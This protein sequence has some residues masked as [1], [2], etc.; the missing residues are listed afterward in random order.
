[1]TMSDWPNV[2]FQ[3]PKSVAA[4]EKFAEQRQS[5]MLEIN[6]A[7]Y[8]RRAAYTNLIVLAGYAG[9]FSLWA[10]VREDITTQGNAAIAICLSVSLMLFVGFEIFKMSRMAL[11]SV[12]VGKAFRSDMTALEVMGAVKE[13]RLSQQRESLSRLTKIWLVMLVLTL[14]SASGAVALL[15]YNMFAQLLGWTPWP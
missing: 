2:D 14:L 10:F 4:F 3:N 7:S 9:A 5:M 11:W 6:A 13:L 8:E 1:M 15:F 12:K